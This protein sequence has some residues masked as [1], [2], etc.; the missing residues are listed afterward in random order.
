MGPLQLPVI[1]EQQCTLYA[2][3]SLLAPA[4]RSHVDPP[5]HARKT[6][7]PTE[8]SDKPDNKGACDRRWVRANDWDDALSEGN[9]DPILVRRIDRPPVEPM[10]DDRLDAI[11]ARYLGAL[12]ADIP[13]HAVEHYVDALGAMGELVAEVGRLGA[14]NG[15]RP[16]RTLDP[17]RDPVGRSHE[18]TA[19]Q[20]PSQISDDHEATFEK[21]IDFAKAIPSPYMEAARP[22]LEADFE[23][24]L[25]ARYDSWVPSARARAHSF[26]QLVAAR[27]GVGTAQ[28]YLAVDHVSHGFG[29]L[30]MARQLDLTVERLVLEPEFESLF[31]AEERAI[32][33]RRLV[34]HGFSRKLLP[35]DPR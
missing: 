33:R 30:E 20:L 27:G 15:R 9:P 11:V 16:T 4:N 19:D 18:G 3:M 2:N 28:A 32:A 21:E 24:K 7:M 34:E 12:P 14:L 23:A 10:A 22:D 31:T 6:N 26:Q 8:S 5:A 1:A 29:E 13:E 25:L 35:P 17:G